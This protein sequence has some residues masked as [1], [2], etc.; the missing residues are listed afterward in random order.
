MLDSC[1]MVEKQSVAFFQSLKQKFIAYLSSSR[2]DC[3]FEIHQIWQSGF[4][5]VYSNCCCSCWFEPEIIKIGR[6]SHKMYSHNILNFQESTTILNAYTKKGLETYWR[7]HVYIY[8]YIY[9]YTDEC[10]Y[11]H[12]CMFL[13]KYVYIFICVSLSFSPSLSLSLCLFM[14]YSISTN[15]Q[16][17]FYLLFQRLFFSTE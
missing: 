11:V 17:N 8:I 3:I 15:K 1:K 5:R 7:H 10:V 2:P 12:A 4:S 6:S 9:I 13:Y 14:F 16:I